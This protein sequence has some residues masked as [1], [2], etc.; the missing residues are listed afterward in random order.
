MLS[1]DQN[2]NHQPPATR[3]LHV[4]M[5]LAIAVTAGSLDQ[6]SKWIAAS[7]LTPG[8]PLPVISDW[9]NLDLRTNPHGAFGLFANLPDTLRLPVLLALGLLAILAV[10]AFSV[11]TLGRTKPILISL[12]LIL[13]GAVSN[14]TDRAL[15]GE[16]L[17][18][19]D[20]RLSQ[21]IHWP[22]FN[23]ADVTITV[24]SLILIAVLL[25]TGTLGGF[26]MNKKR[27]MK[28]AA[29][30]NRGMT[31]IEIMVVIAILGMMGTL[32]TVFFVEQQDQAK[33]D[34]TLIQM[35]NI[36][37]A[38]EAFRIRHGAYPSTEEGLNILVTKRIMKEL[39][40]DMWKNEFQYVRHS[41]RSYTLKSF[42][43]DG[44]SGGEEIDKDLLL[45][46]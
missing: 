4:V 7:V 3:S 5:V 29:R 24:G 9:V 41:A 10:V 22:T 16:V 36:E 15:R 30:N 1:A 11:R 17:D 27:T 39:P 43:G 2:Q 21:Q 42:G 37:D 13:G 23:L 18:F 45:E 8:Q 19:I 35:H 33:V 26:T 38:L 28:A 46:Q 44:A 12:G 20:I 34:S 32:I 31:L 14:L 40:K 6:I 25:K